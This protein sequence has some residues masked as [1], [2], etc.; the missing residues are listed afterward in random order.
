[1]DLIRKTTEKLD[2]KMDGIIYIFILKNGH[3]PRFLWSWST[4][5]DEGDIVFHAGCG[6]ERPPDA[7]DTA[8]IQEIEVIQDSEELREAMQRSR[9]KIR[10][11]W[12]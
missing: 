7:P 6:M 2:R 12:R 3:G 8:W 11:T 5:T 4:R 1:M 10:L 9:A